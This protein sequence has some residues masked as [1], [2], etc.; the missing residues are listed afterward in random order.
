MVLVMARDVL[1]RRWY[2]DD[3]TP[4][5]PVL[6]STQPVDELEEV[7]VGEAQSLAKSDVTGLSHSW[8]ESLAMGREQDRYVAF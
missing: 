7:M 2:E 4:A 5:R 6:G 8:R 3:L 1:G